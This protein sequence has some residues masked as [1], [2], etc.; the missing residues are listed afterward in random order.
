MIE[1]EERCALKPDLV[2]KPTNKA[3]PFIT[4]KEQRDLV[5]SVLGLNFKGADMNSSQDSEGFIALQIPPD[6]LQDVVTFKIE[7][8]IDY[9]D[10]E[11]DDQRWTD[12]FREG[13]SLANESDNIGEGPDGSL[14]IIV[15]V[16]DKAIGAASEEVSIT[17]DPSDSFN[18]MMPEVHS[19]PKANEPR[20]RITDEPMV[21]S[22]ND[23]LAASSPLLIE[24][25]DITVSERPFVGETQGRG[26]V[27]V[28]LATHIDPSKAMVTDD[29]HSQDD[30]IPEKG[31][32]MYYPSSHFSYT[33]S[34]EM[35]LFFYLQ[36][37]C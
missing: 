6:N 8:L 21:T 1:A 17:G 28:E 31:M 20:D 26:L 14:T 33:Y 4:F 35:N 29:S 9:E 13:V 5:E 2:S 34:K 15:E 23:A 12:G 37:N 36:S 19:L 25:N 22:T 27:Q 30:V 10:S 3:H 16:S 18:V 11:K 7:E 24:E 32:Y